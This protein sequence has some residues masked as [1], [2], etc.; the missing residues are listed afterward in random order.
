MNII[1]YRSN[2]V[3]IYWGEWTPITE[4]LGVPRPVMYALVSVYSHAKFAKRLLMH[5]TSVKL[6]LLL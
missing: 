3:G 6:N 1:R 5:N 4:S 2:I